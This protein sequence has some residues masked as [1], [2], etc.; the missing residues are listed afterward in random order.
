MSQQRAFLQYVAVY[1][2]EK[3]FSVMVLYIWAFKWK[4]VM[5]SLLL[6]T[7]FFWFVEENTVFELRLMQ[8][9]LSYRL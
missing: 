7:Q 2:C 3:S 1:K 5:N 4:F 8:P 6:K 9:V